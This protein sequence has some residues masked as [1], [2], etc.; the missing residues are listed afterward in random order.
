MDGIMNIVSFCVQDVPSSMSAG[1]LFT[2]PKG[3]IYGVKS[4]L[5][6]NN[7]G[8]DADVSVSHGSDLTGASPIF[9][10]RTVASG[11]TDLFDYPI[12][13]DEQQS[14]WMETAGDVQ[15]FVSGAILRK[16]VQP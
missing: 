4:I 9:I 14:V 12:F 15:V 13:F 8:S 7:S 11:S 16:E 1:P 3:S 2:V 6:S 5:F 10:N